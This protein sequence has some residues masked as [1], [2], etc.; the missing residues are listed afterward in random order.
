[1]GGGEN[2]STVISDDDDDSKHP[3]HIHELQVECSKTMMTINIEFNRQYD[4]VIYS[5]VSGILRL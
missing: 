2:T 4:G 1:M 5:K 3:P